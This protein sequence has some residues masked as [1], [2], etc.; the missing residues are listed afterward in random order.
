MDYSLLGLI[1]L[2]VLT[3]VIAVRHHR[4]TWSG[5]PGYRYQYQRVFSVTALGLW[6][7]VAGAIGWDL[8]HV[9]GF[10]RG[11]RWVDAPI[12]WQLGLGLA[13]LSLAVF[14]ARRVTP[15]HGNTTR[16][17]TTGRR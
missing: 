14:L 10:V 1:A 15:S 2:M 13:L 6:L 4:R 7:T 9:H 17:V 3:V 8:R 5:R 12:W 16:V 11:T